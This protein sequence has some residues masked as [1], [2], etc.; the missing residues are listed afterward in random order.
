MAV[1]F[2]SKYTAQQIEDILDSIDASAHGSFVRVGELPAP[3]DAN[4]AL[5]YIYNNQV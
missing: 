1:K 2:K 4:A 5:F 3:D